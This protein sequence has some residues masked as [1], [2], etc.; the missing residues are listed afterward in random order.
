[1]GLR[2][3]IM[4]LVALGV[5]AATAPLGVMGLV[6][7]EAA[8][9]RVLEER[10]AMTRTVATH[11]GERIAQGWAY[12]DRVAALAAGQDLRALR[13]DLGGASPW[14]FSGGVGVVDRRGRLLAGSLPSAVHALG[15]GASHVQ[16]VIRTGRPAASSLLRA[17]DAAVVLFC[18]PVLSSGSV[19]GAAVGVIDLGSPV[20]Q[21]F[22]GGMA[23]G[24]TG[25]AV[26]VDRDGTVLASTREEDLFTRNEH[27][28]FFVRLISGGRPLVAPAE[29]VATSAGGLDRHVM[30]FAPV[31]G[32]PWGIGVGQDE[33]ETFG[34]LRRLRDRI[35][36]FEVF[37]LAAALTFAWLDTGAVS[38]P[39]RSLA[40]AAQRIAAGDLGTPV[41]V[42]R[43][44]EIGHLGRSF[45]TM[46]AR[47]LQSLEENA[48]LQE[49]LLSVAVLE[50]RE[51]LA[52]EM[53]DHVG[54][55]LGYVNTK[56]QAVR[57]LVEAGHLDEARRQLAQLEEA[58]R[59]VYADLREA[60]LSLRTA[61]APHRPLDQALKEYVRRFSDLSGL[62]VDLSVDEAVAL[63]A[64]PATSQLHLIR[65]VQ[66]ALTNVRKHARARR[67]EVRCARDGD[68]LMIRVSDD[69]VGFDPSVPGGTGVGLETMRERAAAVGGVLTVRS[70]PGAG[71]TLEVRLRIG[72]DGGARPA[73]G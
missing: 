20:L 31:A 52:R 65:I 12:L 4:V 54:Q 35:I 22:A 53:H 3:R 28:E 1:M 48:R 57:A 59:Q 36:V 39:L 17:G 63:G 66:E 62:P 44:D 27:P 55:I 11:L 41:D 30:A 69:G 8:T 50:E 58:A 38:A 70:A 10:L 6:M 72:R 33:R 40:R 13:R 26:V 56:A 45:E 2:G 32:V 18:V 19:T 9:D 42:R 16:E 34:P 47:L 21:S 15:G 73:G 7:V 46:R 14:L 60:I 24:A 68:V 64:L 61:P 5:L 25:H 29:T 23:Q 71:T 51:R 43:S 49:R 67:A 37:V